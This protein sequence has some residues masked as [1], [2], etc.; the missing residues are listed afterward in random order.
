M[1]DESSKDNSSVQKSGSG[2]DRTPDVNLIRV[3]EDGP[4]EVIAEIHIAD[5]EPRKRAALCR[6]G[7]SKNKPFCDGSHRENGFTAT[8][9]P[10]TEE[11]EPLKESTGRL[12]ITPFPNG[13]LGIAGPVEICSATGRTINR[14]TKT[15]LCRCGHSQSKPYC[16]GSHRTAGF[17]TE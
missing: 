11:S 10:P 14:T 16:D 7:G 13:P 12:E 15:A 2:A 3:R 8:G 9:E 4:L 6:C 1:V 17:T 5:H